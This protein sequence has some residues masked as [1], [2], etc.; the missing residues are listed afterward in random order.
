MRTRSAFGYCVSLR[1]AAMA[2]YRSINLLLAFL[3]ELIALAALCFWGFHIGSSTLVHIVF[4]IGLPVIA[5]ILW[6]LFAAG[7]GPKYTTPAWFKASIKILVYASA[8]IGLVVTGHRVLAVV[9]ALLV[10]VNTALI[11]AGN[12]DA[13]MANGKT[14]A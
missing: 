5:A 2:A 13:G 1:F 3:L 10:I 11:R 4:G 14:G 6:G 7:G 9:F 12:L 8:T